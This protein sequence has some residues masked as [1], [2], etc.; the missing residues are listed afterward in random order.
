MIFHKIPKFRQ[1]TPDLLV[2]LVHECQKIYYL[3]R[4]YGYFKKTYTFN[5]FTLDCS[6][7]SSQFQTI[8]YFCENLQGAAGERVKDIRMIHSLVE[9]CFTK[10]NKNNLR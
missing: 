5:C 4:E 8:V 6:Y 7:I 3:I 10:F 1:F 9:I 2:C